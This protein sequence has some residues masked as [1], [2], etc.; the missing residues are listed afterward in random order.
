[1]KNHHQVTQA[2][3]EELVRQTLQ[4]P[5]TF[6]QIFNRYYPSLTRYIKRLGCYN[7]DDVQD[8]LQ[9]TFISVYINLRDYDNNLKFSSWIYRIAHN[10]TISFFRREKIHPRVA[11]TEDQ[12]LF[13]KM[14]ADDVNLFADIDK[15]Y[16]QERVRR[17]LDKLDVKYRTPLILKFLEDKSYSEIS[18]ILHLPIGTVGTLINRGKKKFKDIFNKN[19]E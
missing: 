12:L 6:S 13:M 14:V 5:A 7:D 9:E 10:K 3:D 15:N 8:I 2:T 17:A 1:M 4:E 18:E 11:A 19:N 16:L